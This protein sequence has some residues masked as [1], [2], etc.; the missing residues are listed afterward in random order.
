MISLADNAVL[1]FQ[2]TPIL[3]WYPTIK[4]YLSADT[5]FSVIILSTAAFFKQ[6]SAFNTSI[7]A[8]GILISLYFFSHFFVKSVHLIL[9]LRSDWIPLSVG[10][11]F[12]VRVVTLVVGF[13]LLNV[14]FSTGIMFNNL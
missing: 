3:V 10:T 6:M 14:Y 11:L 1:G 5:L 7:I 8:T 13:S 2:I 9:V 4:L 12:L